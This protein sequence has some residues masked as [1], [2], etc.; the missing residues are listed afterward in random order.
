MN[1]LEKLLLKHPIL[2]QK[3]ISTLTKCKK[4]SP[5]FIM[6][7]L[8][9]NWNMRHFSRIFPIKFILDHSNF[10]WGMKDITYKFA[11]EEI[12]EKYPTIQWNMQELSDKFN[13]S[14]SFV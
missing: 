11:T 8:H 9:I 12:V 2:E 14:I 5:N 3:Y 1:Y 4:V 10:N 13:I 6:N 7:N